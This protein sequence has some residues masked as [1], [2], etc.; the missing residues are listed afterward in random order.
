MVADEQG[1]IILA[2]PQ[3]DAMFGYMTGTLIG[4]NIEVL[5]PAA[6]RAYHMEWRENYFQSGITHMMGETNKDLIGIRR[7]STT[8]PVEVSLSKLPAL[9]GHGLCVCASVRDITQR[10][11]DEAELAAL[12]ERSRL[13]LGAVGDGIIGIDTEDRITF[14]NPAVPALLGYTEEE[15]IG[16][17]R[18]SLVH[19]AYPDGR[20]FPREECA[21]YQTSYDGQPRQVDNEVL[22]RKDGNALPVEYSI[23]PAYKDG[24]IVGS[25]IVFRDITERKQVEAELHQNLA[26]LE[27]FNR[28]VIGREEKM[29]QLKQEINELR[30]QLGQGKRYK[31][32]K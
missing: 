31:I 22:W 3:I 4:Q 32:V 28:L 24:R 1:V 16:Q 13:I 25:V 8:F 9:G 10:R 19:Y 17:T 21:M 26:E 14:A 15:L 2:N 5:V 20:D 6:M 27:R 18:H 29:I 11:K 7:D 23:T 12:E 30:E